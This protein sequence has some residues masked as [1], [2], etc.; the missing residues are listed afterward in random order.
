MY[1][2]NFVTLEAEQHPCQS[3]GQLDLYHANMC[4]HRTSDELNQFQ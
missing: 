3:K 2:L 4:S 1:G